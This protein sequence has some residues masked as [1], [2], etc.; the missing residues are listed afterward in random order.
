MCS[1]LYKNNVCCSALFA[2][3]IRRLSLIGRVVSVSHRSLGAK[4]DRLMHSIKSR[5]DAACRFVA[6]IGEPEYDF[7]RR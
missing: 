4:P 7:L 3:A 5:L 6:Y 2:R 1:I